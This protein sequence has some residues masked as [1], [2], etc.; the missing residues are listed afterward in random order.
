MKKKF[1]LNLI[2]LIILNILIKPYYVFFIDRTAQNLVGAQ[3]YGFYFAILNF[4][5]VINII[6]DM[7]L[8]NYNNRYIAQNPTLL[9]QV[10]P[11]LVTLRLVLGV[12]YC[13]VGFFIAVLMGYRTR[14]FQMLG[15]LL[16]NQFLLS[17]ILYL[18]SNISGLMK[19]TTD[20][21]IS[22]IDKLILCVICTVMFLN[23]RLKLN[24]KIEWFVYAQTISYLITA[25]IAF[26]IVAKDSSFKKLEWDTKLFKKVLIKSLPYAILPILMSFYYRI[27]MV[28][29]SNLIPGA[30]GETYVGVY[31]HSFRIIEALNNFAYL[32]AVLLLPL[33]A[34]LISENESVHEYVRL[35]T[36]FLV[37]FVFT[38]VTIIFY[39]ALPIIDV[40]Y[41]EEIELSAKVFNILIFSLP[42]MALSY[43][44]GT[45][46]TA[47]GSLKKLNTIAFI[48][49]IL[50]VSLNL[51]L[52]RKYNVIGSAISSV[53]AHTTVI[54]IQ[55]ITVVKM[56]DFN[57]NLKV[58]SNK[59]LFII[60]LYIIGFLILKYVPFEWYYKL[61]LHIFVAIFLSLIFKLVN[62]KGLVKLI[63]SDEE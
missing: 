21:I 8:V 10:F 48:G 9:K 6:L 7:G 52:I 35:S 59:L 20:S 60:S 27:D 23:T 24:F 33:F 43:V 38:F 47:N 61:L 28:L 26:I 31:A 2:L 45:L 44:Y 13:L 55:I 5:F 29:L 4:T 14:Q 50:N 46:L 17:F 39:Y 19:F 63:K 30:T 3:E 25:L 37:V 34:R 18:R 57:I 15:I 40:L 12:I 49:M 16:F 62:L 51:L 58:I 56:F 32:F 1:I 54:T 36:N 42:G 11:P 22:V 53:V 41:K